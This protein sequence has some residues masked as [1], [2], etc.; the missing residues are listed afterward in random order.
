MSD[1]DNDD[2]EQR[3]WERGWDEHERLQLVRMAKLSLAQK[4]EW[5]EQAHRLV[6]QFEANRKSRDSSN[7]PVPSDSSKQE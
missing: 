7:A 5:L 1:A 3:V 4:L 2:H 6:L